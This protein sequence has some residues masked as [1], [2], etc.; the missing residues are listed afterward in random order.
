MNMTINTL[1]GIPDI[2]QYQ[3]AVVGHLKDQQRHKDYGTHK[4]YRTVGPIE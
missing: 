2:T 1:S 4:D 3:H